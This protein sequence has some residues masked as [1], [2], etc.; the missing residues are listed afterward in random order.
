MDDPSVVDHYYQ[1]RKGAEE[2]EE[3]EK[4]EEEEQRNAQDDEQDN[5]GKQTNCA[6][7][8]R[9]PVAIYVCRASTSQSLA[10]LSSIRNGLAI[11]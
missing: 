10:Y 3:E 8:I 6:A 2:E 11:R 1:E 9:F 7:F 4:N 5:C